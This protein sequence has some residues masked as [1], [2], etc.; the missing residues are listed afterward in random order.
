MQKLKLESAVENLTENLLR[1]PAY[2]FKLDKTVYSNFNYYSKTKNNDGDMLYFSANAN[3][4]NGDYKY[5]CNVV[6][7]NDSV[8]ACYT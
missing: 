8:I 4:K 3:Y 1:N 2:S 7:Q 6:V 5:T